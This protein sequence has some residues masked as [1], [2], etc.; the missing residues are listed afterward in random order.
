MYIFCY[1]SQFGGQSMKLSNRLLTL[2]T[3]AFGGIC[4]V[5]RFLYLSRRDI[6]G[7]L[8]AKDGADALCYVFFFCAIALILFF[9]WKLPKEGR[10]QKLFPASILRAVG[11]LAGAV[12]IAY[13]SLYDMIHKTTLAAPALILGILAALC[14]LILSGCRFKGARPSAFLLLMPVIYLMLHAIIQA[15]V[16]STETQAS[17][18]FFPFLASIFLL[19]HAYFQAALIVRQ[20]GVR[21]YVI[22]NLITLLLCC[23]SISSESHLFYL[24]MAMWVGADL[25]EFPRK[26]RRQAESEEEA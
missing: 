11:C 18:L 24:G 19:L 12:T 4:M 16:W 17:I 5:L 8:P 2:L 22:M 1:E 26:T 7:L 3:V 20:T 9:C 21:I 13:T 14:L 25:C 23:I 10:F 15:R 6:Y